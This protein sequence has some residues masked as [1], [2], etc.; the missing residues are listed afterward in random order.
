MGVIYEPITAHFAKMYFDLK[1]VPKKNRVDASCNIV[2]I[3][4]FSVFLIHK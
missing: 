2:P 1:P 3:Y 4:E